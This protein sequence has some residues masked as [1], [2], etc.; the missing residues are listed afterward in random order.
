MHVLLV[1]VNISPG[2]ARRRRKRRHWQ[3]SST[4]GS[5]FGS[6]GRRGKLGSLLRKTYVSSESDCTRQRAATSMKQPRRSWIWRIQVAYPNHIPICSICSPSYL[7][8]TLRLCFCVSSKELLKKFAQFQKNWTAT[9][10]GTTGTGE[11][12]VCGYGWIHSYGWWMGPFWWMGYH[13]YHLKC[14]L[15]HLRSFTWLADVSSVWWNHHDGFSQFISWVADKSLIWRAKA[16]IL[17]LRHLCLMI[18]CKPL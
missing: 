2:R 12:C 4:H 13:S 8:F 7:Q 18:C 3:R 17:L 16:T 14:E 1:T 9:W 11:L 6:R 5:P 10:L 15:L